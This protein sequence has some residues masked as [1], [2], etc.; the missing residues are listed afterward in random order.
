[1]HDL[2]LKGL[3]QKQ[4]TNDILFQN[5]KKKNDEQTINTYHKNIIRIKWFEFV[6][7][8]VQKNHRQ[9]NKHITQMLSI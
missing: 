3:K 2:F 7:Y 4:K 1:M 6:N 9:C 5:N 8:I